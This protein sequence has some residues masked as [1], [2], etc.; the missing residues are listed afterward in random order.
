MT[1]SQEA[2][3]RKSN[4]SMVRKREASRYQKEARGER[5]QTSARKAAILLFK[6]IFLFRDLVANFHSYKVES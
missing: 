1:I 2:S 5:T 3:D 4:L 6:E